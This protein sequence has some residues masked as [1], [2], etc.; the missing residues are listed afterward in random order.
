MNRGFRF[1]LAAALLALPS[2]GLAAEPIPVP[3]QSESADSDSTRQA[4]AD[5]LARAEADSIRAAR[6]SSLSHARVAPIVAPESSYAGPPWALALAGG[7]ARGLAYIGT[8]RALEDDHLRPH[9]VAGTSMGAL[10]AAYYAAGYPSDVIQDHARLVDWDLAFS[11]RHLDIWEWRGCRMPSPWA[12]FEAD[13]G[14]LGLSSG[15][16]DDSAVNFMIASEFLETDAIARG[17]FDRL[18][19][20]LRVVTTDIN[21]MR[22][23]VLRDGSVGEAVR[24]SIGLPVFF[25][26][27]PRDGKALGDG[28]FS[29]NAP[30]QAARETPGSHVASIDVALPQP[31]LGPESPSWLV[32]VTLLDRLNKRGQTD[33]LIAGDLG[34]WLPMPGISAYDFAGVDTMAALAYQGSRARLSA[35]ADSLGLARVAAADTAAPD[36]VLPPLAAPIEWRRA[37]GTR[38]HLTPAA[39]K[40]FG[41]QPAGPFRPG[42]L[43]PGLTKVYRA[44]LFNSAWPEFRVDSA[45]THLTFKVREAARRQ[46]RFTA[47]ADND[48][49]ARAQGSLWWRPTPEG[50]PTVAMLAGTIRRYDWNLFGSLEPHALERGSPGWFG[51]AALKR[52]A[53]RIFDSSRGQQRLYSNSLELMGG[54]QLLLP[55]DARGE[56]SIGWGHYHDPGVSRDGPEFSAELIARRWPLRRLSAIA[57][58]GGDHFAAAEGVATLPFP[59]FGFLIEPSLWL[60]TASHDTP[61]QELPALGGPERLASLRDREW[62]GHRAAGGEVR[63]ALRPSPFATLQAAVQA[64]RVDDSVSRTDLEGGTQLAGLVGLEVAIP[65]GPLAIDYGFGESGARQFTFRFGE[66]F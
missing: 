10:M 15:L 53:T 55:K 35:W 24:T 59:L 2:I 54:G 29:S 45:A 34:V 17:D 18:P 46:A 38:S 61:L 11:P 26:T 31:E 43:R 64:G 37:D 3:F 57:M 19:I 8:F 25:P 49:G 16:L 36:P 60:A 50:I 39:S 28:G 4:A 7:V 44:T 32:A 42:D 22:P 40:I 65:L 14:R 58:S 56:A 41:P 27:M 6:D 30:I 63:V 48:W 5:S 62:S 23:V 47:A 13:S 66:R 21:T 52:T 51:R 9:R 1:V 20:P 12:Q 33:S